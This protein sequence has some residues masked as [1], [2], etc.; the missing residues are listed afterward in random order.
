MFRSRKSAEEKAAEERFRNVRVHLSLMDVGKRILLRDGRVGYFHGLTG[1]GFEAE[2]FRFECGGT[3]SEVSIR[4][5]EAVLVDNLA[6]KCAACNSG[7]IMDGYLRGA[8]DV[9]ISFRER[10]TT[11]PMK[12]PR[13]NSRHVKC[14]ACYECGYIML[15]AVTNS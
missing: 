2:T 6:V 9:K 14:N 11:N 12:A 4:Y 8:E 1:T 7:L 5:Y 10:I 13:F 3:I 15:F